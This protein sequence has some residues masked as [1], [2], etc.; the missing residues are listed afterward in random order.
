MKTVA[1]VTCTF[2][3][4]FTYDV[5]LNRAEVKVQFLHTGDGGAILG[6]GTKGPGFQGADH[7][8]FDAIAKRVQN[9]KIGDLTVGIDGDIDDHVPLDAMGECREIGRRARRVGGKSYLYRT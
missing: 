9:G 3:Q 1:F 6:R 8:G 2:L 7:A 4:V 5:P